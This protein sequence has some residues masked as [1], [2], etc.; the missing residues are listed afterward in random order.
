MHFHPLGIH[1]V[2]Q[3]FVSLNIHYVMKEAVCTD[4]KQQD[5]GIPQLQNCISSSLLSFICFVMWEGGGVM[6]S[7]IV[8]LKK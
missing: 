7:I 1:N 3:L 6:V 2:E 4:C 5:V 8:I